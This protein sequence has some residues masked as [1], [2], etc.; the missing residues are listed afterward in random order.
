VAVTFGPAVVLTL[1]F[2]GFVAAERRFVLLG[3]ALL[4]LLSRPVGILPLAIAVE[5]VLRGMRGYFR[6]NLP[7]A[8][9][10]RRPQGSVI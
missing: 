7:S 3:P 10:S 9:G 4:R 6:V 5:L 2:A 8:G 1:S